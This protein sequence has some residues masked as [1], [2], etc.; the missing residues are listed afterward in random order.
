MKKKLR[1][2]CK[3]EPGLMLC[4]DRVT[5]SLEITRTEAVR[6]ALR[7]YIMLIEN[8]R[9]VAQRSEASP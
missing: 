1:L 8:P 2:E 3:F 6:R 4:L 7:T 9:V 5:E